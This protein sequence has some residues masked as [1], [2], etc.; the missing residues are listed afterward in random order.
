MKFII[1]AVIFISGLI[2]IHLLQKVK[3]LQNELD[4]LAGL[5]FHEALD[6]GKYCYEVKEDENGTIQD[7]SGRRYKMKKVKVD[8]IK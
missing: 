4:F 7:A 8:K 6:E 3:D 1:I 5:L 2:I